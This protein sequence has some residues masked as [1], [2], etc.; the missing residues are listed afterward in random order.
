VEQ[1][2]SWVAP[3]GDLTR[4]RAKPRWARVN[5]V[6]DRRKPTAEMRWDNNVGYAR[7][8]IAGQD[9]SPGWFLKG[10]RACS[11]VALTRPAVASPC[12]KRTIT[13][14]SASLMVRQVG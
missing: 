10:A 9:H 8:P 2:Q 11:S 14:A 6:N 12:V 3:A 5:T 4:H 7:R 13:V 1:T